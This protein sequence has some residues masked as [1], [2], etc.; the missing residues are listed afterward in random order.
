[1]CHVCDIWTPRG[2]EVR[3]SGPH[4]TE[5][6]SHA[7]LASAQARAQEV[8]ARIASA[9]G[10]SGRSPTDVLIVAVTKT[11]PAPALR[12]AF[13]LGFTTFGENRVQEA[14]DKRAALDD[15]AAR[16]ELIGRLQTNKVTRAVEL[17]VRVQSVDSLRL[18]EELDRRA[19]ER[20]VVLPVLLEVNVAG[21]ASKAG[22]AVSELTAAAAAITR[23][24]HLRPEGLMTVAPLGEQAE[25]A[26]PVFR[27]LSRLRETLRQQVPCAPNGGWK[28]LSMGMSDDF[29]IA[30]EEGATIV[31]IGRALFGERPQP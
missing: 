11:V 12:E 22:F 24:P 9:A 4:P 28:E 20:A 29:E 27:E 10:R 23:L 6:A 30:I 19:G 1:M 25:D 17:F 15:L 16:W 21:E 7:S 26:R 2:V 14:R 18:A 31:R 13:A 3:V 5:Q 8:R